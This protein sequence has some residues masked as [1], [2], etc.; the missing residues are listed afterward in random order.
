MVTEILEPVAKRTEMPI[1]IEILETKTDV[2]VDLMYNTR[3]TNLRPRISISFPSIYEILATK[4]S[5][6]RNV[7]KI[8]SQIRFLKK[9]IGN[10]EIVK[11]TTTIQ[12]RNKLLVSNPGKVSVKFNTRTR[13]F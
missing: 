8:E 9:S 1:S 5:I 6:D 12:H 7:A 2:H 11:G 3:T 10:T 4:K 13:Y